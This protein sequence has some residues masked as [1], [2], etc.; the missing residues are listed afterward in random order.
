MM[1]GQAGFEP[2]KPSK[3]IIRV[4]EWVY[5]FTDEQFVIWCRQ[6]KLQICTEPRQ[7]AEDERAAI[8]RYMARQ[9]LVN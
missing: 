3:P 4:P 2:D 5:Y 7:F 8:Y 6:R 9:N 1:Q